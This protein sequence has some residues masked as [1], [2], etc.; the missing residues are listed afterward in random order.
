M[1]PPVK[2]HLAVVVLAVTL[3][4]P[5]GAAPDTSEQQVKPITPTEQQVEALH[6][7]AEQ[8]VQ[9]L[10]AAG[11]QAIMGNA[12]KS[13]A[14]RTADTAAKVVVGVFAAVVAVG[15]TVASLLFL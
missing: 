4:Q 14:R 8:Q 10:D 6:P 5:V 2:G 9:A 12:T 13:P 7:E 1:L 11:A 15:V 3:G